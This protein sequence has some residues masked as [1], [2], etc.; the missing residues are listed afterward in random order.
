MGRFVLD[1]YE[2]ALRRAGLVDMGD[3][4]LLAVELLA[5]PAVRAALQQRYR[6]AHHRR[7]HRL[8]HLLRH[9]HLLRRRSRR[10][11]RYRHLL[12][13]EYQDTN[14]LQLSLLSFLMQ[15][16]AAA[17]PIGITVVGDDDQSIYSFRG[18][19]PHVFQ[20]F[21]VRR[22]PLPLAAPP[23][24]PR[25]TRRAPPSQQDRVGECA[26]VTLTR[27][28]RSSGAIVAA[29]K[30]VIAANPRRAEKDVHT[31]NAHGAPVEVCECRNQ[32]CE[33]D[34]VVCKLTELK[35]EGISALAAPRTH[36]S[37]VLAG[38]TAGPPTPSATSSVARSS[39]AKCR[40][41]KR[42]LSQPSS[43]ASTSRPS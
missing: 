4:H 23:P 31:T 41:P 3:L 8:H 38:R 30:A 28:F 18:A 15:R 20:A 42:A 16:D 13:D 11:Y 43:T 40:A 6:H 19:Q 17:Q 9:H 33:A 7:H 1:H 36:A 14:L 25:L 29:S 27:N 37:R 12:V 35:A 26:V 5:I 21:K 10:L 34:W 32:Q 22:S 39:S 2:K 24:H